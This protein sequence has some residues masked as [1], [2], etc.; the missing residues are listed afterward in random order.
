MFQESVMIS[1]IEQMSQRKRRRVSE[2]KSN[3]TS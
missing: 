1:N 2:D 3:K